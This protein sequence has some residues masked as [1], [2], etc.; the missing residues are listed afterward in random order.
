MNR[1]ALRFLV[2][3]LAAL[4]LT[5]PA[6][7]I[8]RAHL[9]SDGSDANPCTLSLPCRLL[10]A[11]LAV[12]DPGGEIW[13]LDSANFNTAE[14]NVTKSVSILAIPGAVGSIVST[15]G[16]PGLTIAI[17]S[18]RVSLRNLVFVGLGTSNYGVFSY[19]NDEVV[20]SQCE[21]ANLGNFGAGGGVN[22][23]GLGGVKLTIMDTLMRNV[24][25]GVNARGASVTLERVRIDGAIGVAVY[26]GN[27]THLTIADSKMINNNT[28]VSL[29][30]GAGSVAQATISRTTFSG[31]FKALYASI[32]ADEALL[33]VSL[34]ENVITQNPGFG[35]QLY[36]GAGTLALAMDGNAVVGNG[37]G[38]AVAAGTPT[39]FS[40]GNNSVKFN[41]A[42]DAIPAPTG[43]AGQ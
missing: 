36:H 7:A 30:P 3:T 32:I 42:G 15:G 20:I 13:M 17:G 8:F 22:V 9:A 26:A 34:I 38:F 28:G 35:I 31:N 11:A 21:F 25:Y 10:P 29:H 33:N 14:V 24:Y 1:I 16:G 40:R 12:V 5:T 2:S 23:F 37:T 39:I 4:A 19:L 6:H 27:D 43:W 41:S 18:G